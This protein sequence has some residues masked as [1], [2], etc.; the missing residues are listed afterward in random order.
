MSKSKN[1]GK[2]PQQ[3]ENKSKEDLEIK[4]EET[5]DAA[6]E[7]T[8]EEVAEEAEEIVEE[9]AEDAKEVIEEAEEVEDAG[10]EAESDE[11]GEAEE[12]EPEKAPRKKIELRVPTEESRANEEFRKLHFIEK[13]KK[14]PI[15]PVCIILAILALIVAGIYFMLPNAKT[16][17]MGMTLSEFQTRFND[18][19]VAQSLLN[20][21]LDFSFR[22]PE[23]VDSTSHPSVLG[24]KAV[25]TANRAYADFFDGPFKYYSYGGVEGATRKSDGNLS[26]VRVY[27]NYG[28]VEES[29][30]S[31][32]ARQSSILND[33]IINHLLTVLHAAH[34]NRVTIHY[35]L[36]ALIAFFLARL[37]SIV[38][39]VLQSVE[40]SAI[41]I[42]YNFIIMIF[43]NIKSVNIAP[44]YSWLIIGWINCDELVELMSLH[45]L[46]ACCQCHGCKSQNHKNLFH[47]SNLFMM[48]DYLRTQSL[49]SWKPV[50]LPRSV[51]PLS[52]RFLSSV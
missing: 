15:I 7:V 5:I 20:N 1:K 21:G 50:H 4:A 14:D 42:D 19:A 30:E 32:F 24:D 38:A 52:L 29:T 49:I 11:S 6:D 39:I 3:N 18:G 51:R 40:C 44:N 8:D 23:Y 35:G 46:S 28:A 34:V 12:A 16:P 2:K 33:E 47:R 26:Y 13:C 10:E 17:S 27:V 43:V 45:I 22:M 48:V 41:G 31:L 37:L 9:A 36:I 25:I